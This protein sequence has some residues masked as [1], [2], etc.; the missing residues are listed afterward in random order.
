MEAVVLKILELLLVWGQS[1]GMNFFLTAVIVVAFLWTMWKI[2]PA[3]ESIALIQETIAISQKAT[4]E[5]LKQASEAITSAFSQLSEHDKRAAIIERN[6]EEMS[7]TCKN[8]SGLINSNGSIS[9]E[10]H[11]AEMMVLTRVEGKVDRLIGQS[12]QSY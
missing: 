10:Q 4:A 6:Q 11:H 7:A 9:S 3:L 1:A 2:S 8:H 12:S 5:S